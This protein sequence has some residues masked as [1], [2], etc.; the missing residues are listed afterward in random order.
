VKKR[1][2]NP[3]GI[4]SCSYP[5]IILGVNSSHRITSPIFQASSTIYNNSDED[6]FE[7][8]NEGMYDFF[9]YIQDS[10]KY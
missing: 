1:V 5:D 8:N 2:K 10:L 3:K 7:I 6:N 4:Y 9:V